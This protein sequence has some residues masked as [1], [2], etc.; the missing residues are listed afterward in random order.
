M[1]SPAAEV[2]RLETMTN[3][4]A[5]GAPVEDDGTRQV[6]VPTSLNS[7]AVEIARRVFIVL[8]IGFGVFLLF[9]AA[10]RDNTTIDDD[11]GNER[12]SS[13]FPLPNAQAPRQTQVGVNLQEGFDGSLVINGIPIPEEELDGALD[14]ETVSSEQRE[15]LDNF[16]IRPNNRNRL[17]FTPGP[18]KV[19]ESIPKGEVTVTVSYHRDRQPGVDSGAY[20]WSFTVQ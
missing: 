2:A 16:E 15:Q 4:E 12:V 7:P 13:R 11:T 8:A 20:T 17:F 9:I 19:F 5:D 1:A 6:L 14:P 10:G 18:D 3:S